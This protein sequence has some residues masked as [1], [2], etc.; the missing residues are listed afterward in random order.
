MQIMNRLHSERRFANQILR[1][2]DCTRRSR[3]P[4][5]TRPSTSP[6]PAGQ[7]HGKAERETAL[8]SVAAYTPQVLTLYTVVLSV[9][10]HALVLTLMSSNRLRRRCRSSC[11]VLLL[12]TDM[13]KRAHAETDRMVGCVHL[14]T[15]NDRPKNPPFVEA[16]YKELCAGNWCSGWIFCLL[17]WRMSV[18]DKY[19]VPKGTIVTPNIMS[20][21]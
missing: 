18:C 16:I 20:C 12:Y 15:L 1:H 9:V 6:V 3:L 21:T 19:F 8:K 10:S 11:L 4:K 7:D 5:C 2:R 14:P 17:Q 13:Q